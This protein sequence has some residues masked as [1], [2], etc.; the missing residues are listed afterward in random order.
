MYTPSEIIA[1]K[2][3]LTLSCIHLQGSVGFLQQNALGYKERKELE[4][5][6]LRSYWREISENEMRFSSYF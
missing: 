3:P 1:Q 6:P 5:F 4:T 2:G